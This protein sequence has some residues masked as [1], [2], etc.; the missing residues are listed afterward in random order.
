ME[1]RRQLTVH[2]LRI[3]MQIIACTTYGQIATCVAGESAVHCS[4]PTCMAAAKR[5]CTENGVTQ[6][7]LYWCRG[8]TLF[9]DTMAEQAKCGCRGE[10]SCLVCKKNGTPPVMQLDHE[11]YQCARCGV[12]LMPG[13]CSTG[14]DLA[15]CPAP[16]DNADTLTAPDHVIL[17]HSTGT[18]VKFGGVSVVKEFI[19]QKLQESLVKNI[20]SLPW[21]ESVSG[22]RKQV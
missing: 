20:D 19:S 13:E 22:R 15:T 10:R 3:I 7:L 21:A 5:T 16:C 1:K 9:L 17:E 12:L 18:S 14:E 11:F 2:R 8:V 6:K 4:T